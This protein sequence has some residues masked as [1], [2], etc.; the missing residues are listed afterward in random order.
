[1]SKD[2]KEVNDFLEDAE[3]ALQQAGFSLPVGWGLGFLMDNYKL[4]ASGLCK[5]GR[6][7]LAEEVLQIG[8]E[9]EEE[10]L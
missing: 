2:T 3:N 1:M 9:I 6:S 10:V 4:I 7:D 5:V 8:E